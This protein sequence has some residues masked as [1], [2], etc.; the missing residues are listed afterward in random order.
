VPQRTHV[1]L[2][3]YNV[4]GQEIIHL[5]DKVQPAGRYTNT[6]DARTAHGHPIASGIYLYRLNTGSG[7]SQTMRMTLLK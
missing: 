1:T 6:W 4:I 5:V 2:I 7:F 3:F